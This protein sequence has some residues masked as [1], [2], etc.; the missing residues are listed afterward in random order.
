MTPASKS[1]IM[2]TSSLIK[3]SFPEPKEDSGKAH[4]LIMDEVDGMAGNED[5]GG[6]QE[7]INLIKST[8]IPIICMCNDRN[9]Q[10]VRSLANYCFDLRF[11]RPKVD[12]IKVRFRYELWNVFSREQ[13]RLTNPPSSYRGVR[14]AQYT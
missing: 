3:F 4:A 9:S 14:N 13:V 12:Q 2:R 10:K 5:R 1:L 8:K 6:M 7:L 11:Y